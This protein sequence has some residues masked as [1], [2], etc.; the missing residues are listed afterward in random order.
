MRNY[1]LFI[2]FVLFGL[3]MNAQINKVI[4]LEECYSLAKQNYPLVKQRDLIHKS[5]EYSVQNISKGY[6]PQIAI[7]G[8]AT[9]QSEVTALPIKLPGVDVPSLSKDQY[10]IYG[11]INQPLYDGGMVKQQKRMQ[12]A[13]GVVEEQKLEVELYKLKERVNQLFFGILLID[14]QLTLTELIRKDIR[15]GMD[16]TEAGIKNGVAFKTN[17]DVLRAENLKLDQRY[18][19][20]KA[21]R[22]AY[23]DMLSLYLN[24]NLEEGTSLIKPSEKI[25]SQSIDRP[26]LIVFENQS[27]NISIQ[28]DLL[29]AKNLPKFNAFVQ[30]GYG[31]PALN[32]LSNK[33]EP[34]YVGG[35]RMNWS[36]TG[37]YTLKKEKAILDINRQSIDLQKELF[38]FNTNFALKQQSAEV[39]KLQKL[40]LS[41]NQ[42]ILL[43]SDIKQSANVQLQNGVIN[44][45]DYLREVNAEDQA[46][47]NRVLHEIQLLMAEYA[48]QNTIGE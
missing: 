21:N 30:G 23:L 44:S 27:K 25:P 46:R 35:I 26:E 43:R 11:E 13:S 36:L 32:F 6:F 38:L 22:T 15:N 45:T 28:N 33:F 34:Y 18:T 42:I 40:L 47:G 29:K 2:F 20:L 17:L 12:E 9:Y 3:L 24:Q 8:Q 5:K 10:K 41:D 16:R 1:Y 39:S 19:E 37:L 7:N 48:Q 14:E 4:T 31:R